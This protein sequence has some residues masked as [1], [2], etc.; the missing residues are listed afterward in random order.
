VLITGSCHCGNIAF[1]LAWERD[2]VQIPARACG[3]S[4]CRKHGG[5][6][7]ANP[8][9]VLRLR[10]QDPAR[11]SAYAFGTRTAQ[12]HVCTQCGAV[13]ACTSTIDGRTHAVVNVNCFDNVDAAL[14][15]R[16]P[17]SFDD[18][19]TAARLQRRRR[20]WIGN[21]EIQSG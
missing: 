1:S 19:D 13:P 17:V 9:G 6:W 7:T 5:V 21:V 15:R 12:F 2:P 16:M 10:L 3:C 20:N 4:F 8:E 11:V 14:L 18:E